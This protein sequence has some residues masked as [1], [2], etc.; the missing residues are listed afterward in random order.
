MPG[1]HVLALMLRLAKGLRVGGPR[2]AGD[3]LATAVD[4]CIAAAC[5]EF[6][7][8]L[9]RSLLRAAAYGR[10]F[11]R[12]FP[13]DQLADACKTLRV[14]NAV[15]AADVGLPLS[16]AQYLELTPSTLVVRAW[17]ALCVECPVRAVASV[18]V[19]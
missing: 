12:S 1:S 17:S 16:M 15:R 14:L 6:D 11:L 13:P 9:Q 18:V 3:S 19:I 2:W 4:E 10:T 7:I 5:Q 8:T